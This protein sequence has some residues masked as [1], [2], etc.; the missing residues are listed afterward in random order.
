MLLTLLLLELTP[1]S[2]V[3]Y[4]V[5]TANPLTVICMH[6]SQCIYILDILQRTVHVVRTVSVVTGVL[7]HAV[8]ASAMDVTGTRAAVETTA[9]VVMDAVSWLPATSVVS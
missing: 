4:N 1:E 7:E 9:S 3:S 2:V 8:S 6:I 5:I